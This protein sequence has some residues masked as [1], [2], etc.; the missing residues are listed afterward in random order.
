VLLHLTITAFSNRSFTSKTSS[1][2]TRIGSNTA[3]QQCG[4]PLH[5]AN[6]PGSSAVLILLVLVYMYLL[7]LR[8][9][10]PIFILWKTLYH[11][12]INQNINRDINLGR[13]QPNL[14]TTGPDLIAANNGLFSL[15]A[16]PV[17]REI[18]FNHRLDNSRRNQFIR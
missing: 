10:S 2:S 1:V 15:A 11:F 13:I 7:S 5:T 9:P 8:C 3:V 16:F 18:P 4:I 6:G 14:S 17:L 12:R